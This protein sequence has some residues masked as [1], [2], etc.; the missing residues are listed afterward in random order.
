MQKPPIQYARL[1]L[2]FD[3]SA[4]EYLHLLY[5]ADQGLQW[6]VK[7]S[8][9]LGHNDYEEVDCPHCG[10]KLVKGEGNF[11]GISTT[12]SPEIIG[13]LVASKKRLVLVFS[14][15]ASQTEKEVASAHL[16]SLNLSKSYYLLGKYQ[17][18]SSFL[19][20]CVALKRNALSKKFSIKFSKLKKLADKRRVNA[21]E[22]L[23]K[24]QV[25]STSLGLLK[26]PESRNLLEQI[27]RDF[28]KSKEKFD[29]GPKLRRPS[30]GLK[31][32]KQREKQ[33]NLEKA[34][35]Q[36]SPMLSG[37]KE[38][39]FSSTGAKI[40]AQDCE[41][42]STYPFPAPELKFQLIKMAVK[43]PTG[44]NISCYLDWLVSG[45]ENW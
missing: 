31:L 19:Q 35:S 43:L 15:S 24:E 30:G 6:I 44:L 28:K 27:K 20:D 9:E 12:A 3:G 42:F 40:R 26:S 38:K 21:I 7:S 22:K 23:A 39:D 1:S 33:K 13:C 37:L 25:K 18:R 41:L 8:T 11:D 17:S 2:G 45:M 5:C 34:E 36:Q 16:E 10:H 32:L 29:Q 4:N 14:E